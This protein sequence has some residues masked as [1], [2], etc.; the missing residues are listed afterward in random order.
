[1][2]AKP[3]KQPPEVRNAALARSK[4]P[5]SR[6]LARHFRHFNAAAL[7]DAAKAYEAHVKAG[8]RILLTLAG[9]M[10]TD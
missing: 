1:M 2:R 5:V 9:A 4:G 10:Y 8:V 7:L 3:R 6:Y